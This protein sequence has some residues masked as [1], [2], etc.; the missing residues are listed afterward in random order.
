MSYDE[1]VF[2]APAMPLVDVLKLRIED[3]LAFPPNEKAALRMQAES[4]AGLRELH[5]VRK[6]IAEYLH[7]RGL[8]NLPTLLVD[9]NRRF[10]RPCALVSTSPSAEVLHLTTMNVLMRLDKR[11]QI[12]YFPRVLWEAMQAKREAEPAEFDLIPPYLDQLFD[13]LAYEEQ[14]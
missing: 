9:I 2:S 4:A 7:V 10:S 13:N 8:Q 5:Q 12:A 1:S 11:K 14:Q 3:F 6:R